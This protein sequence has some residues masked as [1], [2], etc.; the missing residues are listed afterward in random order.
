MVYME[1]SFNGI[2]IHWGPSSKYFVSNYLIATIFFSHHKQDKVSILCM[3]DVLH[4]LNM[5]KCFIQ[6]NVGE[7]TIYHVYTST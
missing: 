1:V 7:C 6:S 3:Y 5:L 2:I 4:V